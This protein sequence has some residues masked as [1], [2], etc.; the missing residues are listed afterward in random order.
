MRIL[1]AGVLGAMSL[2]AHA[3][4]HLETD[5]VDECLAQSM[6]LQIGGWS[7]TG[8]LENYGNLVPLSGTVTIS[9]LGH[10][11]YRT[12]GTIGDGENGF[13]NDQTVSDMRRMMYNGS[14][15]TSTTC[16]IADERYLLVQRYQRTTDQG[17]VFEYETKTTGGRDWQLFVDQW[18]RI[19][20]EDE[21]DSS[22]PFRPFYTRWSVRD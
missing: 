7:Y 11:R 19:E 10:H 8:Q 13:T 2:L 9:K 18:R 12:K 6:D 5:N 14:T 20:G 21:S 22:A 3:D 1:V 4:A 15:I 16:S 17:D